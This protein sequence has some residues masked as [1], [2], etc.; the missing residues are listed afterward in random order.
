MTKLQAKQENKG[1]YIRTMQANEAF[2]HSSR[3]EYV[4]A[5]YT[6]MLPYSLMTIKLDSMSGFKKREVILEGTKAVPIKTKFMSD[7][8]INVKF[9]KKSLGLEDVRA[10][11]NNDI[12]DLKESI[13]KLE[14]SDTLSK[15]ETK[16]LEKLN[17]IIKR[18]EKRLSEID[19]IDENDKNWK[20]MSTSNLR[21]HL[22]DHGFTITTIAKNTR[23]G[24]EM[25]KKVE[26]VQFSRSSSKSRKGECLFI[27]KSLLGTMQK[28]MRLG[29][30][31]KDNAPA[32]IVSLRAYESLISSG[33]ESTIEID[34]NSIL[35]VPDVKSI[36]K[37]E[38][39]IK[40]VRT[41]ADGKLKVEIESPKDNDEETF[42]IENDIFDGESL[43]DYETYFKD[44]DY[45]FILLRNH[46]FKSAGF[47]FDI[48]QFLKD[49]HDE[50]KPT[51]D[52]EDWEL[53]NMFGDKILASKV[54]VITTPNSCK[55]LKFA[56]LMT[57]DKSYIN[58]KGLFDSIQKQ[59]E[60]D[61]Y[62]E[63]KKIV[64]AEGN[65][66]GVCKHEK[67]STHTFD[68]D[69]KS[70]VHRLSYQIVNTLMADADGIKDL[71]QDETEYIGRLQK[72]NEA[73]ISFLHR[74]SNDNNSNQLY[75]ELYNLNSEFQ[76]TNMFKEFKYSTLSSYKQ[77]LKRGSIH[78]TGADYTVMCSNP[79]ELAYNAIGKLNTKDLKPLTLVGNQ[80]YTKLFPFGDE[81]SAFRNPHSA[82]SNIYNCKNVQ[83]ELIDTYMKHISKNVI[84]VNSIG[85]LL[86]E[87]TSGSDY[88][89]DSLLI[90][91]NSALKKLTNN[92]NGIYV[93]VISGIKQLSANGYV[94]SPSDLAT[95][96]EKISVSGKLIGEVA[97]LGCL[98]VSIHQ[99]F[100]SKG[101]IDKANEVLTEIDKVCSVS[102][103][104]IDLAKKSF[105]VNIKSEISSIRNK[106]NGY[107]RKYR[108]YKLHK[109]SGISTYKGKIN[110]K[111]KSKLKQ[112][113][114]ISKP[115]F[116]VHV[117]EKKIKKEK[118]TKKQRKVKVLYE[119]FNTPMDYLQDIIDDTKSKDRT[120]TIPLK[121]IMNTELK[122]SGA[123]RN[124]LP[125]LRE[126]AE[127]VDAAFA[128]INIEKLDK[129]DKMLQVTDRMDKFKLELS[130]M[131]IKTETIYALI[132]E[133]YN[134]KELDKSSKMLNL[135]LY[136][137]KEEFSNVFYRK[138]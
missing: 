90:S 39:D 77:K 118:K 57:K 120:K 3:G 110:T 108:K 102:T 17:V 44:K 24:K 55:F 72:D 67:E 92:V 58:F 86:Q 97:N 85:T 112:V 116:F 8:I 21:K 13:V 50:H 96:D 45:S 75:V 79:I 122:I 53:E 33:I 54:T 6:G 81:I 26:Y 78:I 106:M 124:Q 93:P 129:E 9:D 127:K 5:D 31:I 100:K 1:I 117:E 125:V 134:T 84:I 83:N 99:D 101:E 12:E 18:K 22:Y 104:V 114:S 35:L 32:D 98:A 38:S 49:Y 41:G 28:W 70:P 62:N 11:L 76:H 27:K 88:D 131:K 87:I 4:K 29:F 14:Q 16:L 128:Q 126:F 48:Q 20:E 136:T 113:I 2:E 30:K 43:M 121:S 36:F 64:A 105:S 95:A 94:Y 34:V 82:S 7:D 40:V 10:N 73:F 42:E 46:M 60:R 115:K 123:N 133:M 51:D 103:C 15:K 59:A 91:N 107:T 89:S 138:S 25:E 56:Y 137:H 130:N 135:L 80:V 61:I 132:N 47:S 23:T 19:N 63:W 109:I 66:F 111:R 68:D 65:T 69:N 71:A 37:I 119:H 74:T 52:Y